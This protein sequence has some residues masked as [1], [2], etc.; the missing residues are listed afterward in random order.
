M[1]FTGTSSDFPE[2]VFTL[3]AQLDLLR[4]SRSFVI[5]SLSKD[6]FEFGIA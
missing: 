5:L 6:L 4:G 3:P 2:L 1:V